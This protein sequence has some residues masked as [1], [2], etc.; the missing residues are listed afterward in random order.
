M[1]GALALSVCPTAALGARS[2][3]A[4]PVRA[5]FS[6]YSFGPHR[7]PLTLVA[8]NQPGGFAAIR[9]APDAYGSGRCSFMVEPDIST[10][11]KVASRF[12]L[13][14]RPELQ[15]GP[16]GL[17]GMTAACE[18]LDDVADAR[19]VAERLVPIKKEGAH[20][21]I[22]APT[23]LAREVGR[24][25][26]G[27]IPAD[28]VVIIPH[29]AGRRLAVPDRLQRG[30][31]SMLDGLHRH[32]LVGHSYDDF[33]AVFSGS[34]RFAFGLGRSSADQEGVGAAQAASQALA[35]L[36]HWAP[37]PP[38]W[39]RVQVGI[40]GGVDLTLCVVNEAALAV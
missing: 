22:T 8:V 2:P 19:A 3:V 29:A 15:G 38:T 33:R 18:T 25:V 14:A 32:G 28:S 1:T 6:G 10:D 23:E 31:T 11:E 9:L 24:G 36:R 30:W 13:L 21:V 20:V 26:R 7:L 40:C 35:H 34:R 17:V 39:R 5:A 12:R 16:P 4:A 27:A 37:L